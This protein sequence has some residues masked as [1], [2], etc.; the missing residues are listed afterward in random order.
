[1]R[2]PR[3]LP[4][5]GGL[6]LTFFLP[7]P[8]AARPTPLTPVFAIH[9][10]ED[11]TPSAPSVAAEPG[12]DFVVAWREQEDDD[13]KI[14]FRRFDASGAPATGVAQANLKPVT[15]FADRQ[16]VAVHAATGNFLIV[17]VEEGQ[18]LL[19]RAFNRA[20]TPLTGEVEIFGLPAP[21]ASGGELLPSVAA[22]PAGF[23]VSWRTS[24]LG[25]PGA[26][27]VLARRLD[28]AG[29]LLGPEIRV[30]EGVVDGFIEAPA[31]AA[32]AA[33]SFAVVWTERDPPF[34][35]VR[36]RLFH[37]DGTPK[38]GEVQLAASSVLASSTAVAYGPDGGF[39]VAWATPVDILARAFG[40]DGAPRGLSARLNVHP[41]GDHPDIA[42]DG[43]GG[44]AVFWSTSDP[45]FGSPNFLG[46][47]VQGSGRPRGPEFVLASGWVVPANPSVAAGPSGQLIAAWNDRASASV[48]VF[49]QRFAVPPATGADPC[50]VRDGR[51]VCD[52]LRG[53][54][55]AALEVPLPRLGPGNTLVLGDFNGD[56]RDDVCVPTAHY[57]LCYL[58]HDG[59]EFDAAV[60]FGSL[61]EDV[62]LLGDVNGDGRDDACLRRVRRF[63]CD[64]ARDGGS[65]EVQILFGLKT[66]LALM[67]DVDGDGDD[68]PCLFR[69]DRFLCDTAHNGKGAEVTVIF[70]L[71]GDVPLLG[72]VDADGD[73]DPCVFR[74]DRFLCDTAHDGGAA[75][76]EISFGEPGAIPLLGNVDGF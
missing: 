54:E 20:G 44:F 24:R 5:L 21:G 14:L 60:P 2:I 49:G 55:N 12:G 9:D 45:D 51:L 76:I 4:L 73:D 13:F 40:E 59:G 11:S 37:P 25:E 22:T 61:P 71:P 19:G 6:A 53:E 65:G 36:G 42:P 48:G 46:R 35:G 38:G 31:V 58:D 34:R 57:F 28:S 8:G 17:W 43:H 50:V 74:G 15:R 69:R 30:D 68:D 1:M 33:G 63:T 52:T 26:F 32:D 47:I 67:G 3:R 64:T 70:G 10:T 72:D 39:L 56:Q 75:E 23:V 18:R 7:A 27:L 66:D 16:D 29:A 62:P 41:D